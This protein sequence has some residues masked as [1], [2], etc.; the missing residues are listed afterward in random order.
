MIQLSVT[1]IDT[2]IARIARPWHHRRCLIMKLRVIGLGLTQLFTWHFSTSHL[3]VQICKMTSHQRPYNCEL[4]TTGGATTHWSSSPGTNAISVCFLVIH[5]IHWDISSWCV[6]LRVCRTGWEGQEQRRE[7]FFTKCHRNVHLLSTAVTQ[8]SA[9]SEGL[10]G[11]LAA[12]PS[13]G[14]MTSWLTSKM[15]FYPAASLLLSLNVCV[16]LV[17]RPISSLGRVCDWNRN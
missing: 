15:T 16:C 14:W 6:Y 12:W 8:A 17:V 11:W 1:H 10:I 2:V 13:D 5:N 9:W 3:Y 4:D 7:G